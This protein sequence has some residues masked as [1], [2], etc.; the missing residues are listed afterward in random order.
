[1]R[2]Q[3][4]EPV[5]S[6]L[7]LIFDVWGP[8]QDDEGRP[9]SAAQRSDFTDSSSGDGRNAGHVIHNG[10]GYGAAV[11]R[12]EQDEDAQTGSG[13]FR[14]YATDMSLQVQYFNNLC[15]YAQLALLDEDRACASA[16]SRHAIRKVI[17]V[18]KC[19]TYSQLLSPL[20]GS[21]ACAPATHC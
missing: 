4:R 19:V 12:Q 17:Y 1:M 5:D 8:L 2:S 14:P 20:P 21:V 16:Y 9:S 18:C 6:E 11:H 13:T 15:P 7:L 10:A 3:T